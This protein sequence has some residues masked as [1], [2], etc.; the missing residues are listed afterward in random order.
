MERMVEVEKKDD[1]GILKM[2]VLKFLKVYFPKGLFWV[3]VK[4]GSS[5]GY[6]MRIKTDLVKTTERTKRA[7][8]CLEKKLREEGLTEEEFERL[9][10]LKRMLKRD[11]MI[12]QEIKRM[13]LHNRVV[14]Q[15]NV[16]NFVIEGFEVGFL[17]WEPSDR[18][19][20]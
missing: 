20:F 9:L 14:V 16:E 6:V 3:E 12:R 15:D 10:Y 18:D 2:R 19:E 4:N 5:V 8:F 17:L 1:L 11:D 7:I 13:L